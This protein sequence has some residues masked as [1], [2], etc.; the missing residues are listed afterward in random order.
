MDACVISIGTELTTGQVV[1]TNAGWLAAELTRLGLQVVGHR[2]VADEPERIRVAITE[3]MSACEIVV[4]TGGI[5][6]TPDDLTRQALAD[7]TACPLEENAE[8]LRQI[9]ALFAGLQR[10]MGDLNRVQAL[11]PRGASVIPNPGGTAPG[12]HIRHS[13]CEL[14]SLPGVPSEMRVMF[15]QYVVPL[16]GD[17]AGGARSA[18]RRIHCF[19]IG[20]AQVGELLG[21]LMVRGRNPAVGTSASE[22]VITIRVVARGSSESDAGY[23]AEQDSVAVRDRLG[24]GVFGSGTDSLESVVGRLLCAAGATASTA[25][26]CTGGLLAK[27]LTDVAGSSAYFGRGFVTYSDVSKSALLEVSPELIERCGAVSGEVAE[28][29]ALGCRRSAGSDFALAIT[30]IAGPTGGHSPEKPVGL[31][32]LALAGDG[33][34]EVKRVLFGE[35]LSRADIRHRAVS[36]SLNMLRLRLDDPGSGA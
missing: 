27:R 32:Y 10:P 33:G 1:D 28:A 23:L 15:S 2:T 17:L 36:V 31:V 30:G 11:I 22:G 25:E 5:G 7:A 21:E 8:A 13:G 34:V 9:E 35:H 19:G 24:S 26:S 18:I 4:C 3:T 29:M 12:I 6:P 16:I 14:F 20:E